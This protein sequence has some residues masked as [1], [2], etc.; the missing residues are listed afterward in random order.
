[1]QSGKIVAEPRTWPLLLAGE[2]RTTA[3]RS[4]IRSPWSGDTVGFASQ[5]SRADVVAALDAATSAAPA[6]AALPSHARAAVLERIADAIASQRAAM[7]H[8]LATEAGKPLAAAGTEIDRA[9]F[10][11]RQGAEE[12]KRIG[13]MSSRPT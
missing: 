13:A 1:M 4:A 12:A 2:F 5:G 8:L 3:D 7:A 10:V 9:I 11:F 6:A